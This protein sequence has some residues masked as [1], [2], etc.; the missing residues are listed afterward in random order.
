MN[1]TNNIGSTMEL[2]KFSPEQFQDLVK[3]LN[4]I[5]NPLNELG[6]SPSAIVHYRR[7]CCRGKSCNCG[8]G[9]YK[10]HTITRSNGIN[11]YLFKNVAKLNCSLC[12]SDRILRFAYCKSYTLSSYDQYSSDNGEGLFSEMRTESGCI[13][14]GCCDVNLEVYIP[15]ENRLAGIVKFRNACSQYCKECCK[16][17]ECCSICKDMCYDFFYA[18]DILDSN[19]H[20]IYTIFLR[21]CCACPV[22]C[23]DYL[24]F[25]IKDQS[26][27]DVGSIELHTSCCNC[28]YCPTTYTYNID[29]PVQATPELKLAIIN[30]VIAIDLFCL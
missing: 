4:Y 14:V 9:I 20:Q 13:C 12:A 7:D 19:R 24:K 21:K 15:N 11:N 22:D 25:V 10:Y 16:S 3:T 1:T 27:V 30:G 2:I 29:F 26:N 18:C 17:K 28:Y 6:L 23:C 8:C 5:N